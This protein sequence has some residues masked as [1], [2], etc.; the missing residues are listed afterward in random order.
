MHWAMSVST[1]SWLFQEMRNCYSATKFSRTVNLKS[2]R[3]LSRLLRL[4]ILAIFTYQ[5]LLIL[6]AKDRL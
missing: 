5:N 6:T 1:F 2:L 3:I 4:I